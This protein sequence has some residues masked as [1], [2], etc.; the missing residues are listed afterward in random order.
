MTSLI[1]FLAFSLGATLAMEASAAPENEEAL[2]DTVTDQAKRLAESPYHAPA[3]E[4]PAALTDLDYDAYRQIRFRPEQALWNDTEGLFEVQLFHPGFLYDHP[5]ALNLVAADGEV[6]HLPFDASRFRYEGDAAGLAE[7]NLDDLGYAGFRLHYPL[8]SG[9]YRD[10]FMV[11]LG[12]SYFRMVGREQGYGLSSRGLAIDTASPQGEEFPAFREFWLVEPG[13]EATRMT[14]Y[15]LLDSPSVTG[16]YRFDIA[17]GNQTVVDTEARLFARE[18]IAKLGIAPLTSMFMHGGIAGYPAD[19][20]RLRVHDSSGLALH[21]GS[22]ERIWRPLSNPEKLHLSSFQDASPQGFGL[23]QRPRHFDGY[24]DAEARYEQRPSEWVTPLGDWG[25]G[26]VE[27]VE[28]P[29]DSEANDNITAY[30]IPEQPLEAGQSRTFRYRLR[31]F[32]ATPPDQ[33]LAHVIRTRQGWGAIPGQSDPPPASQRHFI[34]DFQGTALQ[35]LDADQPVAARLT[36]SSGELLEPRVQRLPD[37]KTWRANFR[38]APQDDAPADMR[39]ALTL[40]GE[41]LTETWNY[42]WYPDERR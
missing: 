17:P 11:F 16:A 20:Y 24:L 31:T 4:L 1:R 8:N 6:R 25:K 7:L 40:H 41:P 35:G 2:F 13:P 34:V 21:T 30:W 3:D 23:V 9:D 15:A 5:V 22:G 28:I 29:S 12:A 42:V 39:L 38:L 10:E 36:T 18:D 26:H 14:V 19:D 37:G 32:G 33:Q 27:L